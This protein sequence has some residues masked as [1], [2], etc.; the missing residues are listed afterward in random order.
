M[1]SHAVSHTARPHTDADTDIDGYRHTHKHT[2]AN[3]PEGASGASQDVPT[4]GLKSHSVSHPMR[5]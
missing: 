3:A 5:K 1:K 4:F 2:H